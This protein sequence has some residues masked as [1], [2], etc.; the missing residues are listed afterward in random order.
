LALFLIVLQSPFLGS[1]YP[2]RVLRSQENVSG[3]IML[4]DLEDNFWNA[5]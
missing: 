1:Q 3:L 5:D 2:Y 4:R